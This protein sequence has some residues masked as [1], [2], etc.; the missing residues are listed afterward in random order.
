[1]RAPAA[2]ALLAAWESGFSLAA[3]ARPLALLAL[4]TDAVDGKLADDPTVG[5]RDRRLLRLRARVFGN[6]LTALVSCPRCGEPAEVALAISDLLLESVPGEAGEHTLEAA[7]R[8]VRFRL[9]TAGDLVAA[10]ALDEVA[11]ARAAILDRCLLSVDGVPAADAPPLSELVVGKVAEAM[12][13]ADPQAGVELAIDCP[14]CDAGWC[15]PFDIGAFFWA[16]LHAWA[17]RTLL[18][19][20]TLARAYGWREADVLALSSARRKLYVEMA[21]S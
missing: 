6:A 7:G 12:A 17:Q 3:P 8:A 20:H 1:M 11:L 19:V 9:P 4:G 2:A 16:E 10:A 14:E 18:D 15:A 5:E 21:T 13:A